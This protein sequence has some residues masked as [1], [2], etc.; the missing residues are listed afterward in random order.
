MMINMISKGRPVT[1]M[2]LNADLHIYSVTHLK[3]RL[4]RN[5]SDGGKFTKRRPQCVD[6]GSQFQR[7]GYSSQQSF[8]QLLIT[9]VHTDH[10]EAVFQLPKN[11]T[12]VLI[13]Q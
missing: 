2:L 4:A 6:F 8:L 13:L 10:T 11:R 5:I 12:P 7:Y 9:T 3:I 1:L